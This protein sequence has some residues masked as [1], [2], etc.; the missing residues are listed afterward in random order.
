[1]LD[2]LQER[3]KKDRMNNNKRIVLNT[4]VIYIKLIFSALIGLYTSRVILQALGA[5]DYGLYSVVGG[6][7]TFLNVIGTTMVSVSNRYIAVELGKGEGGNPNRIFN[8]VLVIHLVLALGLL[9]IGETL[10]VFYVNN[11]LNVQPDKIL[12]ARFVLHVSLVTT[13]LSII[14]VPYNGLIVAREKFI[15][16]SVLELSTLIMKLG[17]VFMLSYSDSNRLRLFTLIMALVSIVTQIA[18]QSYCHIKDR[19]II[20]WKLNKCKEDYKS[21]FGFAWWSL[22]G[23][24]AYIGKEQGAAMII[25]F[26]F[27][28]ILNAAFGLATQINRYAMMFTKGLSQAAIPQIMKSFSAGNIDRSLNLVYAISRISTL[29]MLVIVIP[30]CLCMDDIL[31]L[32]LKT[33]PKYTSIF[34]VFMLINALVSMVGAGF[35]ACIQST[36]NVK[37]NE[38]YSSLIYLSL[39]PAIFIMYKMGMPPYMN[40]VILPVL[41]LG[42]RAMQIILLKKMTSFE[43][44]TFWK[45]SLMPSLHTLLLAS[46]PLIGLRIFIGHTI[47]E[48]IVLTTVAVVWTIVSVI[49]V[50]MSKDER[51]KI[52]GYIR[53]IRSKSN[54]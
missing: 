2:H 41:S 42:I 53:T 10:G 28:T 6:I 12:D 11:L 14:T 50:G 4:G 1:M 30:L 40:V 35:D 15:F 43:F 13:A 44:S 8:T 26:F 36:G 25:N 3:L 34:A 9:L 31:V 46:V 37:K 49:L 16:T 21:V 38:I 33:P 52:I 27:G 5:D 18:Y 47:L 24:I 48:T 54:E 23:A 29:I 7:V 17:L 22:F 32:W 20:K 39:L 19:D 45:R 51:K